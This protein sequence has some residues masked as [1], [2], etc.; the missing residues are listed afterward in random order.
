MA[1]NKFSSIQQLIFQDL[2]HKNFTVFKIMIATAV[3]GDLVS[4]LNIP[5]SQDT[6]HKT[7]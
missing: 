1:F 7:C 5:Y 4:D 2:E 6:Q 3:Q